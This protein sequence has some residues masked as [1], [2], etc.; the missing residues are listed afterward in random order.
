MMRVSLKI[1][2][3]LLIIFTLTLLSE[4]IS[5]ILRLRELNAPGTSGHERIIAP[6]A[7]VINVL[8]DSVFG[9]PLGQSP[10]MLDNSLFLFPLYLGLL[11][12]PFFVAITIF[13]KERLRND[14]NF[15]TYALIALCILLTSGAVFTPESAFIFGLLNMALFKSKRIKIV[16][17]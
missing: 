14:T 10:I 6:F 2:V 15:Y 7:Y 3:S 11:S 1:Q 13:I 16:A 5:N 17:S 9:I 4:D 8:R 12:I